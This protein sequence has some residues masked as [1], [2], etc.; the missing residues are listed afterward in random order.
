MICVLREL[1]RV[2]ID[3]NLALDAIVRSPGSLA[4]NGTTKRELN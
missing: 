4:Q 2:P 1:I 3:A